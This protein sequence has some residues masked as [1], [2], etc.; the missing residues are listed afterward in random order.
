MSPEHEAKT[1][2]RVPL[3]QFLDSAVGD[4]FGLTSKKI[5]ERAS[6]VEWSTDTGQIVFEMERHESLF[7]AE[8]RLGTGMHSFATI[9][10][11]YRFDPSGAGSIHEVNFNARPDFKIDALAIAEED[12][13]HL[14]FSFEALAPE[15]YLCKESSSG[16]SWE[17]SGRPDSK[18]LA[19]HLAENMN[20]DYY[21]HC[22]NESME[23]PMPVES[24]NKIVNDIR[25]KFC[26]VA[27]DKIDEA[28]E[29]FL[30]EESASG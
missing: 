30:L 19:F 27:A 2:W 6:L 20:G 11:R 15:R 22:L 12:V 16:S 24:T 17:I 9:V 10:R 28:W 8:N 13:F 23:E 14:S 7:G 25:E 1:D 21:I 5:L 18:S 29:E 26:E 3:T 4:F